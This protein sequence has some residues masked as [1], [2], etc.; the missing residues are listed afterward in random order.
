MD[1]LRWCFGPIVTLWRLLFQ[2]PP[3]P[4]PRY[5]VLVNQR[6]RLR[7]TLHRKIQDMQAGITTF[8]DTLTGL[9]A[10]LRG[11][12][13]AMTAWEAGTEGTVLWTG[14]CIGNVPRLQCARCRAAAMPCT[15]GPASME[16]LGHTPHTPD[17]TYGIQPMLIFLMGVFAQSPGSHEFLGLAMELALV[18]DGFTPGDICFQSL[19]ALGRDLVAQY[20]ARE[21]TLRLSGRPLA[22]SFLIVV[23]HMMLHGPG[24]SPHDHDTFTVV[25]SCWDLIFAGGPRVP[26]PRPDDYLVTALENLFWGQTLHP[27]ASRWRWGP[28]VTRIADTLVMYHDQ[29]HAPRIDL[30]VMCWRVLEA[31][32]A[33]SAPFAAELLGPLVGPG[34]PFNAA[35]P[36]DYFKPKFI[37]GL[38]TAAVNKAKLGFA[39]CLLQGA[40]VWVPPGLPV[41]LE[42][43][44]WYVPDQ[45]PAL[46]Q[47]LRWVMEHLPPGSEQGW[48]MGLFNPAQPQ[49]GILRLPC[50]KATLVNDR[51]FLDRCVPFGSQIAPDVLALRDFLIA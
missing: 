23:S 32:I 4:M 40:C 3:Q 5:L 30:V 25:V 11:F 49:H 37:Q 34:G 13:T 27:D 21:G 39:C 46:L 15:S 18:A 44:L 43:T 28:L 1:C 26:P 7:H 33:I 47:V 35:C 42:H 12:R 48:L 36:D 14:A 45:E 22:K 16:P 19:L 10:F 51:P 6:H 20:T 50:V 2:T 41:A 31:S 9:T 29:T 38:D 24:F 17:G 8:D